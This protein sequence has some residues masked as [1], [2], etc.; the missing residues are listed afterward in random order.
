MQ[1]CHRQDLDQG[2]FCADGET[3]VQ[4]G[5]GNSRKSEGNMSGQNPGSATSWLCDFETMLIPPCA[6]LSFLLC[7]I[8]MIVTKGRSEA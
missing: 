5:T 3:E 2:P 8:G 1:N 7:N 6:L 4:R